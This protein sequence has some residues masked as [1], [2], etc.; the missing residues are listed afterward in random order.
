MNVHDKSLRGETT[1][2]VT[3]GPLTGSCKVYSS[4]DGH[5]AVRVPLREI[6]LTNGDTFNVYDS[7]GPYTD[8]DAA[9]DVKRGLDPLRSSWIEARGGV[10]TDRGVR[11]FKAASAAQHASQVRAEPAHDLGSD[12]LHFG[13]GQRRGV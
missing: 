6:E 10:E 7:S 8:S 2:N 5:E 11:V 4:P 13:R 3:T 1:L 9:I 12:L